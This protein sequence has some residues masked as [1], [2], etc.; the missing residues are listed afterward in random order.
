MMR[1]W[2]CHNKLEYTVLIDHV[3]HKKLINIKIKEPRFPLNNNKHV[4]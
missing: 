3:L 2:V 4:Y 1:G